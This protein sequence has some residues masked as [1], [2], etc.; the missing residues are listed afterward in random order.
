MQKEEEENQTPD[1]VII[2]NV[3]DSD[4]D[5]N[6]DSDKSWSIES[7]DEEEEDR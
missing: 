1:P 4:V 3:D 6:W 2:E 7:E 5:D